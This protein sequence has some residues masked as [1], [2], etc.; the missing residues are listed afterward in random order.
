MVDEGIWM[1]E[2]VG[3]VEKNSMLLLLVCCIVDDGND[4]VEAAALRV[5]KVEDVIRLLEV[6]ERDD[7]ELEE[8]P[9][10]ELSL[11]GAAED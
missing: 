11:V 5:E 10:L 8:A 9:K 2:L 7:V 6:V 1:V 4:E 3:V